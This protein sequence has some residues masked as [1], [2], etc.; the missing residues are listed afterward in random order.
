LS[1]QQVR[2][3]QRQHTKQRLC[4]LPTRMY[5][6]SSRSAQQL[7]QSKHHLWA[8]LDAAGQRQLL[9]FLFLLLCLIHF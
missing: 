3:S 5:S 2:A 4:T 7:V 1:W 6:P 8:K 9:P